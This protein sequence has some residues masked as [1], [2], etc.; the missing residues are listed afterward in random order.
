VHDVAATTREALAHPLT[1][2]RGVAELLARRWQVD[3][4]EREKGIVKGQ[5]SRFLMIVDDLDV[6]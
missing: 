2:R 4:G 6:R 3:L 5:A 1:R